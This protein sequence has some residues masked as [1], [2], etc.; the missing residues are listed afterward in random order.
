MVFFSFI[1]IF[2]KVNY[3]WLHCLN[4]VLQILSSNYL[5]GCEAYR[6]YGNM[7]ILDIAQC[8]LKPKIRNPKHILWHLDLFENKG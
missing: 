4:H 5:N 1:M 8:W 2:F 3:F 7:L 6:K